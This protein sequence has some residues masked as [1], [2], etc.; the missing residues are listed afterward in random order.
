MLEI[1]N[2]TKVYDGGTQALTDVSFSVKPGE[3]LA[4]I[5]LSGSGKSTL[6]RCIN[7]LV[8]PTAGQIIWEGEDVT[9]ASQE[10]M[11]L[12]RRKIGMVFQHFAYATGAQV[13]FKES[14][15]GY[16]NALSQW[17]KLQ[18][19]VQFPVFLRYYF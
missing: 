9:A 10:E 15:F 14:Y 13:L 2:L 17:V 1:K 6:L 4:V 18:Q 12:I 16:Q 5:G 8:E 11:R 7:R 3:F 19:E